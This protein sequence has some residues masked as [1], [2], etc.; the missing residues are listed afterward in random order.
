MP[1]HAFS[2]LEVKTIDIKG[3]TLDVLKIFNDGEHI[4]KHGELK[5]IYQKLN[6]NAKK[7]LKL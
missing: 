3:Q 6:D 5:G 2:L 4:I 1:G 7:E